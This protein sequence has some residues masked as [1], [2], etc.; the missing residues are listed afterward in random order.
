[1]ILFD[2]Q[3]LV[4]CLQ[5]LKTR[6]FRF[7]ACVGTHLGPMEAFGPIRSIW[8]RCPVGR[9]EPNVP[10]APMGASGAGKGDLHRSIEKLSVN[11]SADPSIRV[12]AG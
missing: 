9:S 3:K 11:I 10:T 2:S 5:R 7:V 1:M 8:A 4:R 6:P 12:K